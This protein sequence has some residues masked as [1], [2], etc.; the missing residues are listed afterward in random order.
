MPN[1]KL[2]QMLYPVCCVQTPQSISTGIFITP[3]HVLTVYHGISDCIT[4]KGT[5]DTLQEV[6]HLV[7]ISSYYPKI[8]KHKASIVAYDQAQDIALLK[9]TK[10]SNPYV[11]QFIPKNHIKNCEVF[12]PLYVVGM[13]LGHAP[14]PTQGILTHK[15]ET[16]EN[17]EY[18]MTDAWI[19]VG[20]SGSGV[21]K[22]IGRKYCLIGVAS[23]SLVD[24]ESEQDTN[25]THF[26]PP[27]AISNFLKTT[28]D[29]TLQEYLQ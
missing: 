5:K 4:L 24:E 19:Q 14:V 10:T 25:L 20:N 27:D 23:L 29:S 26:I 2:I 1:N 9:L 7:A 6:R 12:D 17:G 28:N 22:K 18:W 3:K 11:S 15:S 16:I 21:F 13:P 8:K